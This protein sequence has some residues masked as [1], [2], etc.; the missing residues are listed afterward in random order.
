LKKAPKYWAIT[1]QVTT[2]LLMLKK[3]AIADDNAH[4]STEVG[5]FL[6]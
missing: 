5:D 4:K 3:I 1:N 6:L 2:Q